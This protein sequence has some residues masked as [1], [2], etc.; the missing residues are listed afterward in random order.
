MEQQTKNFFVN[1]K[2]KFVILFILLSTLFLQFLKSLSNIYYV[3]LIIVMLTALVVFIIEGKI[4]L[5]KNITKFCYYAFYLFLTV[6]CIYSLSFINIPLGENNK[7]DFA[8]YLIAISRMMI[9]PSLVFIFATLFSSSNDFKKCIY[10][11]I[12]FFALGALSMIIQQFVGQIE[13]LGAPGPAR[14]A[15]LIPYGSTLGNITIYGT[16]IGIVILMTVTSRDIST[17]QKLIILFLLV[18]F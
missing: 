18:L 6:S 8:S 7:F 12:I 5:K 15:G 3:V 4:Y 9:M 17:F 1:K 16:A 2:F 14:Y 11:Y 13:L 10:V